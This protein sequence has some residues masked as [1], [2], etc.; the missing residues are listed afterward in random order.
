MQQTE[1][2]GQASSTPISEKEK[3]DPLY[4]PQCTISETPRD[5]AGTKSTFGATGSF[6]HTEDV[7]K[8]YIYVISA[9]K[10]TEISIFP[11]EKISCLLQKACSQ[12]NKKPENMSLI[13]QGKL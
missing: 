13:F 3:S 11:L 5:T 7:D 6:D 12:L 10:Q 2:S 8:I 9:G 1:D 4:I